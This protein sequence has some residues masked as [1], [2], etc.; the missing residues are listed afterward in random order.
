MAVGLFLAPE[1]GLQAVEN[2]LLPAGDEF[3]LQLVLPGN[4]GLALQTGEH[5]E[6]DLGLALRREDQRR[7]FGMEGCFWEASIDYC[8]GPIPAAHFAPGR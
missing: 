4:L 2:G 1:E 3:V 7:R 5:F 8:T 6:D